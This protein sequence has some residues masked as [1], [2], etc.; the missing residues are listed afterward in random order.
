M[1]GLAT[2]AANISK[3]MGNST[4]TGATQAE[5]DK[6]VAQLNKVVK[7]AH[8][9]VWVGKSDH[10]VHR[11]AFSVD[12]AMDDATKQ[13]QGIDSASVNLDVTT[14]DTSAPDTSAPSSLGTQSEF[15]AALM[16]LLGKVMSSTAMG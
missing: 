1:S 2:A 8:V 6:V 16:A 7:K 5:I 15:Q 3:S 11:V 14:V 12:A 9:D 13:S 4:A 10:K